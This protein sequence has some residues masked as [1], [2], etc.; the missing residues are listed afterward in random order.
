MNSRNIFSGIGKRLICQIQI[1][2]KNQTHTHKKK[3]AKDGDKEK[4]LL[5]TLQRNLS[6][7]LYFFW[8]SKPK[9][10]IIQPFIGKV[11]PN[12]YSR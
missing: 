5:N 12:L 10:F 7:Y 4:P 1:E 8:F 11:C 6:I 9:I 2:N 3:L